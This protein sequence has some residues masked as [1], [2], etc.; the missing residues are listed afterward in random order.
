MQDSPVEV[1]EL[2]V[3]LTKYCPEYMAGSTKGA[4][5]CVSSRAH[6]YAHMHR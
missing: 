1:V 4:D 6:A 2:T 5:K 3:D